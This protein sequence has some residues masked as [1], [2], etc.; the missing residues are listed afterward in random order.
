MNLK[1]KILFIINPIS[2]IGRQKVIE[3]VVEEN[4][5][6]EKFEFSFEYTQYAKHATEIAENHKNEFDIIVAVGGDGSINEV[7]SA[8]INSNTKLA[9]IPT[10]SGNGF[11]RHLNIPLNIVEAVRLI[12]KN[13]SASID[14]CKLNDIS[15]V[16]VAGLGFDGHISH[17][18][19]K[20]KKRGFK[21]YIKLVVKNFKTYK[22]QNYKLIYDDKVEEYKAF[23]LSVANTSQ[24]GNNAKIAPRASVNDGLIDIV[25]LKK[26]PLISAPLLGYKLFNN[27]FNTSS[28]VK[29][30][31]VK[32]ITIE[33]ENLSDIHV[34]GE[35]IFINSNK[36]EFSIIPS[37]LNVI[38][39]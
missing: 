5:V 29:N 3:K 14:T 20:Q 21:N 35:P 2:G 22:V 1:N 9:V 6:I 36:L 7:A 8:L 16:N 12:N 30:I 34:D 18:F 27:S 33:S 19:A 11:A 4:L 39:P 31:K 17:L 28:F 24:F 38:I 15:F 13:K 32:S 10:G 23:M 26:F 37:S 25:I